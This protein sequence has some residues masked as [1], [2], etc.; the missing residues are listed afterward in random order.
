MRFEPSDVLADGRIVSPSAERNKVPI[1]ELL[2]R[3]LPGQGDVLE[4]SSGTGQHVLQFAQ[5]MPHIRWQPTEQ[6]ADCLKSIA[7]WLASA[8]LP[9]VNAPIYLDVHDKTWRIG[10]VAAVVCLNMIHIAP[11]SATEALFRGAARVICAVGILFLYGPYRRQGRHISASNE[12][13]DALLRSKNPEWG[14][15]NLEDVALLAAPEGFELEETHDM[16]A[17][18]LALVLR[19]R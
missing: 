7:S 2:M 12:A 3:V 1:T 17:N 4:I 16:P 15:R 13:F 5:A 11:I 19:K 10:E 6:D 9:N 18:N 8:P 14:I